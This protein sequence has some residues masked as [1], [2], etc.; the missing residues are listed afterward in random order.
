MSGWI[1]LGF[2]KVVTDNTGRTLH[3]LVNPFYNIT[4]GLSPARNSTV[5]FQPQWDPM[6]DPL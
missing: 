6:L 5:V 1:G 2:G 4:L 3:V